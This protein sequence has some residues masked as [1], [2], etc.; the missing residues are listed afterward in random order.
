[1]GEGTRIQ[2]WHDFW[3]G[4]KAL[5]E[6]FIEMYRI[7]HLQKPSGS[8]PMDLPSGELALSELHD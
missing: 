3:C 5:K 4:N 8:S 6:A 1:M 2:L 7:V